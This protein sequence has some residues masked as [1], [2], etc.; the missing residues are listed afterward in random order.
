MKSKPDSLSIDFFMLNEK[1][2]GEIDFY[3]E[4]YTDRMQGIKV[5][6]EKKSCT[7]FGRYSDR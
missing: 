3:A 6:F 5:V 7:M 2:C 1:K 4:D